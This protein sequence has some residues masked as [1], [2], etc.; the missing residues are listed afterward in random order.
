M[1]HRPLY[2]EEVNLE[3]HG[4]G[5]HDCLQPFV[6]AAHFFG[7]VPALPYCLAAYPP[8]DCQYTL[9][10]YRPGSCPPWRCNWPP[11][12]PLAGLTQAGV[13]AGLIILFP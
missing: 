4:Y 7:T 8:H 1:F 6:S 10:H 13:L 5:H 3:R 2:F 12:R 9:G 11:A